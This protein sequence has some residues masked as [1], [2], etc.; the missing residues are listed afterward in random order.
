[1]TLRYLSQEWFEA[2]NEALSSLNGPHEPVAVGYQVDQEATTHRWAL[3]G[4]PSGFRMLPG[5]D[6]PVTLILA[7]PDAVAVSRGELSPQRAFLDGQIR[8]AG[9]PLVLQQAA[10]PLAAVQDVLAPLRDLTIY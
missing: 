7:Y 3:Q 10:G 5:G 6:A 2:A 8:L 1:M 4:D 9:E